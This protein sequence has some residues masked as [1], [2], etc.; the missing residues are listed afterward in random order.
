MAAFSKVLI[1]NRGEIACRIM[2]S[3]KALGYRTVAVFSD[4]DAGALHVRQADEA[5]R[6][7]PAP[8]QQSYLNIDALLMAAKIAGADAIHPGYGFLSESAAFARACTEVGLVFVGP[9]AAAIEAMG[10]KARAKA[11]MEAAGVACVPGYRGSDQTDDRL[12]A[13]GRS[14]GFPLMV[15]AAAGGGGR[16]MRLVASAD[17][18]ANAL[19][20]ARSEAESAFGSRELI[21]ERVIVNARHIEI[22]V[23]ADSHGDMIHLGERDCSIQRRHQK[24]IEETPSPAVAA[25]LRDRIGAAAVAAAKAVNYVGAGTVEF[26]LD[27][28]GNFYFLEM[29]TR[30][31]VEHPVT[32]AVTGLDLVAWQLRIAAGEKLP[33]SQE[34]VQIRGHAIEARLYAEDPYRSFLPQSGTLVDWRPGTCEGV[35]VDHGLQS[36][37]VV[38]PFY[39][40]MLAKM[41][42]HG[43]T[44]EEAR[45]RLILALEDTIAFGLSTNRSFLAAVLRHPSFVVGEATTAFIE[46]HFPADSVAMQRPPLDLRTLALAA[47]LLFEAR[48]SDA[49]PWSSTGIAASSLQLTTESV[50]QEAIVAVIAKGRYS[51]VLG[52]NIIEIAIENRRTGELRFTAEGIQQTAR[53]SLHDGVLHLDVN[54]MV[55]TVREATQEAGMAARREGSTRLLAPMNGAIISVQAKPGDRVARGQRIV[56]LEAMKMQHELAAE[57]DGVI[58]KVLVKPGDQVATRQLLVELKADKSLEEATA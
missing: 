7:G 56:V 23:F 36:G 9:P 37:A 50:R 5:V 43:E 21:L 47:V 33:L 29:N 8:V 11:L 25:Q 46:R 53:F 32:E 27:G 12:L 49:V 4:A 58:D 13:E 28:A 10:N 44:R 18:L 41:V 39:D 40:P 30:L 22:Q 17:D 31:Q 42:A 52:K 35:R 3:A 51:I 14:I 57:R 55:A 45:R 48:K 1:A 15:K 54:G 34:H 16:G 6:I 38:S 26:L 24:V 2:R 20:R 19:Q